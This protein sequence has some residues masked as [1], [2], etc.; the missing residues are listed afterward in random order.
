MEQEIDLIRNKGKITIDQ[1][2]RKVNYIWNRI[3]KKLC[4]RVV[5]KFN[6]LVKTVYENKGNK[7]NN[8]NRREK[9]K[10]KPCLP[11]KTKHRFLNKFFDN[12]VD[13]IHRIAYSEK[14]LITIRNMYKAFLRMEIAFY[15]KV[16]L[17]VGA[18]NRS[19]RPTKKGI[20]NEKISN[21]C[22]KSIEYIEGIINTKDILFNEVDVMDEDKFWGLF[23]NKVKENLICNET[24][25]NRNLK[26][27]NLIANNSDEQN[28]SIHDI[29]TTIRKIEFEEGEKDLKSFYNK[30]K[31][32]IKQETSTTLADT[33]DDV[34]SELS[35][36]YFDDDKNGEDDEKMLIFT[37]RKRKRK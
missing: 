6:D 17:A 13:D 19:S 5:N 21:Y 31:E 11:L 4:S 34:L 26:I 29:M 18:Y 32:F 3:P 16:I 1:L 33:N 30:I 15:K 27:E 36:D 12:Y 9:K 37:D 2:K 24:L 25:T 35:F 14:T 22:S 8:K 10:L 20:S 7:E 23:P 28:R